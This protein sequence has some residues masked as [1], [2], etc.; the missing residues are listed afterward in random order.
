MKSND[1]FVTNWYNQDLEMS[2]LDDQVE[3]Y[4]ANQ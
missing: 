4:E 2:E 1:R 3:D